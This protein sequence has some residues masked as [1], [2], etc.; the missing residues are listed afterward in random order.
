MK[1]GYQRRSVHLRPPGGRPL[2]ALAALLGILPPLR[3]LAQSAG[4][5]GL[6]GEEVAAPTPS[7]AE[8]A[9]PLPSAPAS[10][11]PAI[12]D[13]G[14]TPPPVSDLPA[15]DSTE[16]PNE[17]PIENALSPDSAVMFRPIGGY[18]DIIFNAPEHAPAVV[19]LS[20]FVIYL[21]HHF[22]DSLRFYS[23]IETEH[24]ITSSTDRGAVSIAQAYIDVLFTKRFN[25]RLGL[26]LLPLSI[27]SVH[28]SP[29]TYNGVEL[30]EVNTLVV[31][32]DWREVG[33][34]GFGEL[35]PR[36]RYQFAA[37][38]GLNANHFTAAIPIDGGIQNGEFAYA[39]DFG[40]V[41]RVDW[42][43]I[44]GTVFGTS[45]YGG[46]SANTLRSQ[47]GG[48]VPVAVG[49]LD[50]RAR[51]GG[52]TARAEAAAVFIGDAAA[53]NRAYA[54]GTQDQVAALPVASRS[55]GAYVEVAYNVLFV[56]AP[57]SE[58]QLTAFGQLDYVDTQ[59]KMPTGF[60]AR[61]ELRRYTATVGLTYRPIPLIAFKL[62]YRRHE[63]GAGAGYNEALGAMAW[64]F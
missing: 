31:P 19:D 58:Q 30:A 24:A 20:R 2:V 45:G 17:T 16:L 64:M 56:L 32:F 51:T 40:G 7:E 23:E 26:L 11:P 43:P 59:A 1:T 63:F 15:P 35:T 62:D 34:S 29:T 8:G 27:A 12:A 33:I 42:E 55:Q 41:A 4:D 53:L 61:P 9:Q 14:V 49:E 57:R 46:T 25:L 52:L 13:P 21:G 36:L 3:A 39:G 44:N 50:V 47:V 5:A 6:A 10:A 60:F 38:N 22:T 54:A 48:P 37:V 28:H 18:G